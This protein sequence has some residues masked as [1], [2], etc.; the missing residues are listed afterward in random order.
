MNKDEM[1][2]DMMV[3]DLE[4]ENRLLRAGMNAWK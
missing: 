2:L 1:E 3:A 4:Q